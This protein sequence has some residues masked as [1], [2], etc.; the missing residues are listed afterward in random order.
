MNTGRKNRWWRVLT[1][2]WAVSALM[3]TLLIARKDLTAVQFPA[4]IE[5]IVIANG[6]NEPLAAVRVIAS[7]DPSQQPQRRLAPFETMTDERGH[8]TISVERAGRFRIVPVKNGFI[9]FR[10]NAQ[11]PT[12]PGVWVEIGGSTRITDLQ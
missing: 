9:Q 8:F 7:L 3:S 1:V 2:S 6:T 11:V 12:A 4:T 5:G 10:P